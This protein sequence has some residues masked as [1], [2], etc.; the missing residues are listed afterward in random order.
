MASVAHV[1]EVYPTGTR[2]DGER[3]LLRWTWRERGGPPPKRPVEQ[4]DTLAAC[5]AAL[6]RR[7]GRRG[8]SDIRVTLD[9]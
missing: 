7:F 1:Y 8:R 3:V 6:R 2:R 4:F 5:L 9:T